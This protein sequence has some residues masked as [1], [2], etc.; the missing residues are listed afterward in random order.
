MGSIK[1]HVNFF[2]DESYPKD[3]IITCIVSIT[4]LENLRIISSSINS[5]KKDPTF[6]MRG[7][8]STLHFNENN[9]AVEQ[10]IA[11]KLF[12]LPFSVYYIFKRVKKN[13]SKEE[14]DLI[15]Y[16]E[17]LPILLKNVS[18]K[19]IKI[20]DK[21]FNIIKLHF[22]NLTNKKNNDISFFKKCLKN[23][24]CDFEI[25]IINKEHIMNF[26]PDYLLGFLKDFLT[27]KTDEKQSYKKINMDIIKDK[28]GLIIEINRD[29]ITYHKRGSKIDGFI[30]NIA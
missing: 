15:A 18:R 9:I 27:R 10:T 22:E 6:K 21:D 8:N 7:G 23:I 16:K 29:K 1:N 19:Y 4:G 26:M 20:F 17:L 28:I 11:N 24:N 3:F 25:E 2:I 13:L 14:K 12:E 5:I 30:E